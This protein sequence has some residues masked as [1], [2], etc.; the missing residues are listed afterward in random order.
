MKELEL[1]YAAYSIKGINHRRN[2]D[3][4][5]MLGNKSPQIKKMNR[6]ELFAV[7]DGMS[8][9]PKGP[10]AAQ[11]MCDSLLKIYDKQKE[12]PSLQDVRNFLF[13]ANMSINGW[14]SIEKTQKEMGAC[15]GTIVWIQGE[16]MT[17][18]HAG[19]T[20]GVL[21]RNDADSDT[22]YQLLNTE[23][24]MGDTLN[25]YFGIGASIDIE[26]RSVTIDDGDIVILFSDG[27]IKAMSL[28]TIAAK[29]REWIGNSSEYAVKKLCSLA[30]SLGS[31][32]DITAVL[33][34]CV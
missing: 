30:Q 12:K 7:F 14:G 13:E 21:I 10:E 11:F 25:N 17:I 8:S 26:I 5:R 9:A 32:D 16:T 23:H 19:D 2:E 24:A 31:N 22:E 29:T 1:N 18:F 27:I 33:I 3:R 15:A 4:Y 28:Q 34:E 6:G 20:F